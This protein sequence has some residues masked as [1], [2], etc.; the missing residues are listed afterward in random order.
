[1]RMKFAEFRAADLEEKGK[2]SKCEECN[3]NA[4]A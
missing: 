4:E 3:S 2:E 1:M